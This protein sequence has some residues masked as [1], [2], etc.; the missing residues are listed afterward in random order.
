MTTLG[1]AYSAHWYE[2]AHA[3]ANPSSGRYDQA[4]ARLAWQRTLEFYQKH[5]RG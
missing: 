2:A 3:F 4:D 1:K 5:L